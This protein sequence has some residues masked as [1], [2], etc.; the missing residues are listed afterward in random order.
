MTDLNL[1]HL[2]QEVMASAPSVEYTDITNAVLA[3]I[4]ARDLKAALAQALPTYVRSVA[5]AQR[6]PGAVTPPSLHPTL[7][8]ASGKPRLS[9]KVAVIADG[10]QRRLS[11]IYATAE[12]NKRLG[13]F[14][15][16]DLRYQF[17]ICSHQAKQ[18]LSK[19]KGWGKLADLMESQDAETI[20][21]LPAEMLMKT[22]GSV[23]A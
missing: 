23:A 16:A 10:W 6:H 12:G 11:E 22:L 9:F 1:R 14:T 13:D 4:D 19:A 20:R 21:D 3:R 18:K 2:V 5:V 8:D 17:E 7:T 15:V